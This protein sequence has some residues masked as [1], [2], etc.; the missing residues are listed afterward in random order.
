[1]RVR[2][3]TRAG[4]IQCRLEVGASQLNGDALACNFASGSN[5]AFA[6]SIPPDRESDEQ[7]IE[8]EK[9]RDISLAANPE[10]VAVQTFPED[11]IHAIPRHQDCEETNHARHD[12]A[13]LCPPTGEPAMQCQDITK[14]RAQRPR[15]PG[16]A[17]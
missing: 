11:K 17:R 6:L 1:M 8:N 15:L 9:Y 14:Q 5:R 7:K 12:Q 16:A 2:R 13:E 4:S 3:A 10:S